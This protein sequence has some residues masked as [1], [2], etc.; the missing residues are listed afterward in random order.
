MVINL[1]VLLR[2]SASREGLEVMR[3]LVLVKYLHS[4]YFVPDRLLLTKTKSSTDI[5]LHGGL[6]IPARLLTCTNDA[7]SSWL[8]SWA[9]EELSSAGTSEF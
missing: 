8:V 1:S 6:A 2:T 7:A 4:F 3:D 9:L 5:K